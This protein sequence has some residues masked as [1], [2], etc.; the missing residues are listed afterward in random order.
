MVSSASIPVKLSPAPEVTSVERV[1]KMNTK[2]TDKYYELADDKAQ[3]AC[4]EILTVVHERGNG[5]LTSEDMNALARF[6][7]YKI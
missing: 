6:L 3:K 4:G 5:Y 2:S 7:A 1:A